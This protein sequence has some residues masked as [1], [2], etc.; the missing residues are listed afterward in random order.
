MVGCF[1]KGARDGRGGILT[2]TNRDVVFVVFLLS[3]LSSLCTYM[4]AAFGGTW[5][6]VSCV[7]CLLRRVAVDVH[8]S[9]CRLDG[10]FCPP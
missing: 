2:H 1:G 3:F 8:R 9:F 5:P 4:Y 7:L 10:W 6:S